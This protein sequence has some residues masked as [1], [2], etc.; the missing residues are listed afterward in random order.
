MLPSLTP[1][2]SCSL[3]L[4]P[5]YAPS[6]FPPRA[7]ADASARALH[8]GAVGRGVALA[9]R[10]RRLVLPPGRR[11][12]QGGRAQGD[13]RRRCADGPNRARGRGGGVDAHCTGRD[14]RASTRPYLS[15]WGATLSASFRPICFF[16]CFQYACVSGLLAPSDPADAPEGERREIQTGRRRKSSGSSRGSSNG[17]SGAAGEREWCNGVGLC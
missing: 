15:S 6:S 16:S 8:D 12:L 14:R 2:S 3:A 7:G 11:E 10:V 5:A 9:P 13:G 1:I 17:G 4:C